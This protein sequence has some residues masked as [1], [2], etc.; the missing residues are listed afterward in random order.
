MHDGAPVVKLLVHFG[1]ELRNEGLPIGSDE[2][3][4]FC[5][6]VAV[7]D[8]GDVDDLYWSGRATLI[9]RRDHISIYDRVFRRFFLSER[10][11]KF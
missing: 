5:N 3:N 11:T 10:E 1:R 8:P 9:A 7:L 6:A 4:N 2:I